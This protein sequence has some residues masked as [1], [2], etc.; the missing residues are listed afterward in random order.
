[1]TNLFGI[2]IVQTRDRQVVRFIFFNIR[3]FRTDFLGVIRCIF[4]LLSFFVYLPCF[5]FLFFKIKLIC[6]LKFVFLL[7]TFAYFLRFSEATAASPIPF[8]SSDVE[9]V[10][11]C[12]STAIFGCI[13]CLLKCLYPW[14]LIFLSESVS[15]KVFADVFIFF[16]I[17][18]A[19]AKG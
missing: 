16:N 2:R 9:G 10:I 11:F 17:F 19:S 14:P 1:M 5:F 7:M 4:S 13:N 3:V 12:S 15:R 8:S 6:C 18:L